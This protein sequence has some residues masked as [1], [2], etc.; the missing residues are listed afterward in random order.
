MHLS[1]KWTSSS[2][3]FKLHR[4]QILSLTLRPTYH[5]VSIRSS[6]IPHLNCAKFDFSIFDNFENNYFSV[7]K[8]LMNCLYVRNLETVCI[9]FDQLI[10]CK[11]NTRSS[12]VFKST[13]DLFGKLDI[14]LTCPNSFEI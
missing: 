1:K 4:L 6:N 3:S 10:L 9:L 14:R 5:P 7:Q 13:E 8:L 11:F 2:V 12:K